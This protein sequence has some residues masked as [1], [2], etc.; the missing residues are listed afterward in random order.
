AD[1]ADVLLAQVAP[2]V[3]RLRNVPL[4][5]IRTEAPKYHPV[6]TPDETG[7]AVVAPIDA[8]ARLGVIGCRL[9]VRAEQHLE[10]FECLLN[11]RPRQTFVVRVV[12]CDLKSR[13][14][15]A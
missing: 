13:L 8:F 4:V 12:I 7:Q 2:E 3:R 9:R 1:V 6:K 5:R 11:A 15:Q 10:A 14:L